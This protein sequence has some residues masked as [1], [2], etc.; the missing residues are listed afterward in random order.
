MKGKIAL[1]KILVSAIKYPWGEIVTGRRHH[2]IIKAMHDRGLKTTQDCV[3]GFLDDEGLFYTRAQAKKLAMENGQL[4]SDT[5]YDALY[6]EDL[7]PDDETLRN[8]SRHR[9]L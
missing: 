3:Q 5:E 6:S 4:T 1:N 9:E 8:I 7:W 2:H